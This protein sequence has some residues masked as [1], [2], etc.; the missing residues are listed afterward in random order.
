MAIFQKTVLAKY[1]KLQDFD[2]VDK[3]FKKYSKYFHNAERQQNIRD[4]KEEQFQEGFLRELFVNVLDYTLNPEPNFNLTTELKNEKNAKK[5][6]WRNNK[7]WTSTSC[8]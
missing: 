1:L 8:N 5:N 7:R 2:K 3:A 4:S 6:R